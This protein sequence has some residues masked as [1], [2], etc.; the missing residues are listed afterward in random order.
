MTGRFVTVEDHHPEGGLADA[1]LESFGN[2]HADAEAHPP[3]GPLHARV[4]DPGG[5][6]RRR[7]HRLPVHRLGGPPP[8]LALPGRAREGI[9]F[10]PFPP[11]QRR[12]G[13]RGVGLRRVGL[14]PRRRF[15]RPAC[16]RAPGPRRWG[17]R[18][19]GWAPCP[20][21]PRATRSLARVG[22]RAPRSRCPVCSG[23]L[24]GLRV[25]LP[26]VPVGAVG[27]L[28]RVLGVREGT[29]VP[30]FPPPRRGAGWCCSAVPGGRHPG[31]GAA[32]SGAAARPALRG[33]GPG[34]A[35]RPPA[36]GRGCEEPSPRRGEFR[37][38]P[39]GGD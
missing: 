24:R 29:G 38:T 31:R 26:G 15:R 14:P 11:P 13:R 12:A 23:C 35:R 36:P 5:T 18:G 17:A 1:V 20:V 21:C 6:A 37:V 10:P 22:Q 16:A 4:R 19:D 8:H 27:P 32:R 7:G 39:A 34:S 28:A 3:R 2:G 25:P 33:A 9:R 30:S